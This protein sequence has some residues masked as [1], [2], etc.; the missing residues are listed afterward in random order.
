MRTRSPVTNR[1]IRCYI[2]SYLYSVFPTYIESVL[3]YTSVYYTQWREDKHFVHGE[4][5]S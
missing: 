3:C 5:G 1:K 2:V 4:D